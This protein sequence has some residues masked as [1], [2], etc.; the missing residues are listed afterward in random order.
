MRTRLRRRSDARTAPAEELWRRTAADPSTT[1]NRPPLTAHAGLDEIR[2][3]LSQR[4]PLYAAL[5]Q[6]V[7][8]T[9]GQSVAQVVAAVLA[10]LS[11]D[12]AATEE[13]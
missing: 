4:E 13:L 1:S 7:V 3:L 12:A 9:A 8:S 2:H 11:P 5:A 10:V 6:H